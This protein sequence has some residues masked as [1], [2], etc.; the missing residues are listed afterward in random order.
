MHV[1]RALVKFLVHKCMYSGYNVELVSWL[2]YGWS[3]CEV[4]QL[5]TL[6]EAVAGWTGFLYACM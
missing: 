3:R 2:G 5:G 1:C 4:C 6:T